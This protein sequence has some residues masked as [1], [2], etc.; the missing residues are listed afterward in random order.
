MIDITNEAGKHGDTARA[1]DLFVAAKNIYLKCVEPDYRNVGGLLGNLGK[2][3]LVEAR[4]NL[5]PPLCR[6][7]QQ[8]FR[9]HQTI[10]S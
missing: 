9:R 3:F 10:L 5:Q 1:G 7:L 8:S 2:I 4:N 6:F